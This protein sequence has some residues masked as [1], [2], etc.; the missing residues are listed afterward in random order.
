M[1]AFDAAIMRYINQLSQ[2]SRALDT[3]LEL[4]CGNHLLKGGVIVTITWW[5]WFRR[6]ELQ[7]EKREHIVATFIS[8]ILGIVLARVLALTLPFRS[9]PLHEKDLSFVLP[10]GVSPTALE[11][12]SS[13]PSDHCVLFF[14]LSTGISFV[15]GR[16]GALALFYTTLFIAFPRVY[17]GFHYPT[18][19]IAGAVI[20]IAIALLS[21]MYLV[22]STRLKWIT[23]FSHSEPGIF[24]SLFF[25]FT[26]QIADMFDSSRAIIST[27]FELYKLIFA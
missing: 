1:N 11:D 24:Y 12:W 23:T 2:H 25:L 13:F 8:C 4:F 15:S 14:A 9:R 18:D 5:L 19:I 10:Y 22:H 6:D 26:Y 7:S 27:G 3:S 21:N 17:T 20:G 16:L